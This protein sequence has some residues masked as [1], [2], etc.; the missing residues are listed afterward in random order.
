LSR[1]IHID[2]V[3]KTRSQLIRAVT[4]ALRELAGQSEP[5]E[6]SRDLVAFIIITLEQIDQTV[7][8][9]VLA[10]EKRGYWLKADR[11][12]LEWNWTIKISQDLHQALFMDDWEKIGYACMEL[13]SKLNSVKLPQRNSIGTPWVGAWIRLNARQH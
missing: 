2:G 5:D 3:G 8:E 4:L 13:A 9:T 10:W 6:T 12:R 11:F 7:E 1:V